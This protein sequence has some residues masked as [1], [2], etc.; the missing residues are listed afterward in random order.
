MSISYMLALRLTMIFELEDSICGSSGYSYSRV[1]EV[2]EHAI[3]LKLRETDLL[4]TE[5][6][7]IL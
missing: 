3:L 4:K 2:V 1:R 7:I 6:G 5:K